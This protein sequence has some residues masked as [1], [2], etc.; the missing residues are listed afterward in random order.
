MLVMLKSKGATS[1]LC[2]HFQFVVAK[3]IVAAA[4]PC[5]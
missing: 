4:A 2:K 5:E 3:K 1:A